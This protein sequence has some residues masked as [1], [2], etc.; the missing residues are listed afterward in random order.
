MVNSDN[1]LQEIARLGFA[2]IKNVYGTDG[3]MIPPHKLPPQ[4]TASIVKFS[5]R[6]IKSDG[7]QTIIE[8]KYQLVDKRSSL[9]LLGKHLKLFS[10]KVEIETG[11]ITLEELIGTITA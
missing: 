11:D 9:E 1:V 7:N 8:R 4:V 5:E 10:D 3:K 6:V 2:N